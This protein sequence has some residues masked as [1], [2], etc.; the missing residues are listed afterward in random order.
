LSRRQP[1]QIEYKPG[2][3]TEKGQGKNNPQQTERL[4][5]R[6]QEEEPADNQD[7]TGKDEQG[8]HVGQGGHKPVNEGPTCG[9]PSRKH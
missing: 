4:Q 2:K 1:T 8:R 3:R 7:H 6:M 5:G 9:V